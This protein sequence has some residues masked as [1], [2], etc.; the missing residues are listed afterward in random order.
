[1]GELV[2]LA[3]AVASA[4]SVGLGVGVGVGKV[5]AVSGG[6]S[7]VPLGSVGVD[8]TVGV[9]ELVALAV[10]MASAV[11]VSLSVGVGVGKVVAVSGGVSVA[12]LGSVG[13]D[14]AVGVRS[15]SAPELPGWGIVCGS[16]SAAE[17]VS[18]Q[19]G[20]RASD[21]PAGTPG[22]GGVNAVALTP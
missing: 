11:S 16:Q 14:V 2:A 9:G 3:V 22:Q 10:A 12:S 1:M 17:S 18:S 15:G 5:V 21:W 6:V 7:V 4:V 8:V 19:V 13:V 20:A